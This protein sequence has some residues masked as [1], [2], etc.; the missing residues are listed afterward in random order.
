M[1]GS[2][3][4]KTVIMKMYRIWFME[5]FWKFSSLFAKSLMFLENYF[6]IF[7]TSQHASVVY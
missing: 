6:T 4:I 3:L 2:C 7:Y 5:T 1:A